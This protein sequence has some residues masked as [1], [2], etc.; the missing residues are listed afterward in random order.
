MSGFPETKEKYDFSKWSVAK[1]TPEFAVAPRITE[2]PQGVEVTGFSQ[3]RET[4]IRGLV[5]RVGLPLD[6]V[7]AISYR[8]NVG[9][10]EFTLGQAALDTGEL[11]FYKKMEGLP[12]HA[13]EI[14]Q[15]A[16][17]AHELTHNN[18]ASIARNAEK[19]GGKEQAK[20][21]WENVKRVTTQTS[22]TRTFLTDYHKFIF[23]ENQAGRISDYVYNLET[24]AIMGQLRLTNPKK[25]E[26]V[27][28]AQNAFTANE[29]M[30]K[31]DQAM[32]TLMGFQDV[33]ELNSHV[34]ALREY[35]KPK[36][37]KS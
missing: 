10:N 4:F 2:I 6:G 23:Q 32:V 1:P 34:K 3:E 16:V 19:Y 24:E 22:Q 36:D 35:Y 29:I 13:Q 21:A 27:L 18:S 17:A 12:T 20:A 8:P 11:F 9:K 26:Q 7:T 5:A 14:S 15:V 25:L 28:K 33:E 37:H 31:F 30:G